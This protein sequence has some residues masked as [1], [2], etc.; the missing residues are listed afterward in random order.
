MYSSD[1]LKIKVA[2]VDSEMK[3]AAALSLTSLFGLF[4][5]VLV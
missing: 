1:D 3:G 5:I 2:Q 4:S